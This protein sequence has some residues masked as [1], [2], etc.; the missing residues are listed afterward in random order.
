[1]MKPAKTPLYLLLLAGLAMPMTANAQHSGPI[2]LNGANHFAAANQQPSTY[3]APQLR[4]P[5]NY[6]LA[7]QAPRLASRPVPM[8]AGRTLYGPCAANRQ[9]KRR[10]LRPAGS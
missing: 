3:I 1:M 6:R 8:P 10:T 5:G 2:M 7:P 9:T 4:A